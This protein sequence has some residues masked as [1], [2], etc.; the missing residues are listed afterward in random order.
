MSTA[1]FMIIANHILMSIRTATIRLALQRYNQETIHSV[2]DPFRVK[3]SLR[4]A[5]CTSHYHLIPT[6]APDIPNY[7][8]GRLNGRTNTKHS[9]LTY[10]RHFFSIQVLGMRT[11]PKLDQIGPIRFRFFRNWAKFFTSSHKICT[12]EP[13]KQ[14]IPPPAK[15]I[16]ESTSAQ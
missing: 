4:E 5:A 15:G 6:F 1:P 8:L 14:D 13:T 2:L 9:T 12:S 3:Y 10:P 11:T 16:Q 7:F